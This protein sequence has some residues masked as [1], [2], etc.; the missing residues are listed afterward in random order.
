MFQ[1]VNRHGAE[2]YIVGCWRSRR[3]TRWYGAK[4]M[5]SVADLKGRKIG[6]RDPGDINY[7]ALRYALKRFGLDPDRDVTFVAGA[8]FHGQDDPTPYLR[9]GEVDCIS[10]SRGGKELEADGY[11]MLLDSRDIF[12]QGR[13][14][15]VIIATR[16]MVEEDTDL[17]TAYLRATIRA[18]WVLADFHRT[19]W[20]TKALV[21]RLR[22]ACLDKE[23]AGRPSLEA[24]GGGGGSLVVP[25]DG[26]PSVNALEAM[27]VE[28]KELGDIDPDFHLSSVLRLDPVRNAF[29]ELLARPDLQEQMAAV[30]EVYRARGQPVAV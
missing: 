20:Y 29:K 11:P 30:R 14:D 19:G 23:E 27:V 12:P 21:G 5:K 25:F 16:R 24:G 4:G 18:Y 15:R 17:L 2:L 8:R 22:R 26:A 6:I 3:E 7:T 10:S 13:T 1:L 9:S 28:S